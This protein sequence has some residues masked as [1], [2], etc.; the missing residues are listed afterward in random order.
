MET[1][2]QIIGWDNI[3]TNQIL[4]EPFMIKN[5]KKLGLSNVLKYQNVSQFFIDEYMPDHLYDCL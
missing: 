4:K 5:R 2:G 3:T 1:H